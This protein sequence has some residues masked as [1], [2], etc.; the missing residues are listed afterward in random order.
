LLIIDPIG[1]ARSVRKNM[2]KFGYFGQNPPSPEEKA[3]AADQNIE[4]VYLPTGEN[5]HPISMLGAYRAK[6]VGCQGVIIED[7]NETLEAYMAS[8][9]CGMYMHDGLLDVIELDF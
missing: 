1:W 9:D 3:A 2:K 8:M 4:L 6:E 5:A 7:I